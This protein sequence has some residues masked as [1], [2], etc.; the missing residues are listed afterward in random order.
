MKQRHGSLEISGK[1]IPVAWYADANGAGGSAGSA[2]SATAP[3]SAT[4]P[5]V[6]P[7]GADDLSKPSSD[8]LP[9]FG[10]VVVP[11]VNRNGPTP[12]VAKL[13]GIGT[14]KA[15]SDALFEELSPGNLGKTVYLAEGNYVVVQLIQKDTP[16][17]D[18]FDKDSD[19]IIMELRGRR[20]GA[21]VEDFLRTKCEAL[22]K[23]SRIAWNK[24]LLRETGADGKP[25][26]QTYKPC[27]SFH[28]GADAGESFDLGAPPVGGGGGGDGDD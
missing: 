8:T 17:I 19:H 24:E 20:A 16:K 21:V 15:A 18:D 12:K 11:K 3:Q 2:G 25:I 27:Q 28:H 5:A 13:P 7:P 23:G 6:P 14:S 10:T 1:D 4:P 22:A 26:A 9:A